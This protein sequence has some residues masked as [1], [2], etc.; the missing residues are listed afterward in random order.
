ME[1]I[2][3]LEVVIG[4]IL[5][6]LGGI[7]GVWIQARFALDIKMDEIVAEKKV[8]ANQEAY[9]RIKTIEAMLTQAT[10]EDVKK[11]FYEYDDWF[12]NTR[13]FL[14]DN[15]PD[16]WLSIKSNLIKAIGLQRELP[17]TAD[18]LSN[19]EERLRKLKD[20]AIDAIYHDMNLSKIKVEGISEGKIKEVR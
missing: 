2:E 5:A 3:M 10:L 11:Q 20:E 9:S 14:P 17:A 6:I 19:L 13:L 15:F 12:F 16:K 8:Q 4:G 18:K 7:A 1:E